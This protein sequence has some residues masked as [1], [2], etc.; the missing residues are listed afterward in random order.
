MKSGKRTSLKA[1][2]L[3][4]RFVFLIPRLGS[5]DCRQASLKAIAAVSLFDKPIKRDVAGPLDLVPVFQACLRQKSVGVRCS[6]CHCLRSLSRDAAVIRTNITDSGAGIAVYNLFKK[7][8]EDIRVT[9]AALATV[10]NLVNEFSPL[11]TV[12]L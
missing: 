1:E 7:E 10:C 9:A 5:A 6:A 2:S 4:E 8:D 3:L 12:S 11:R